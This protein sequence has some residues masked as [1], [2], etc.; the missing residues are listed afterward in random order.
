MAEKPKIPPTFM[1]PAYIVQ[2]EPDLFEMYRDIEVEENGKREKNGRKIGPIMVLRSAQKGEK[3][4]FI[5]SRPDGKVL[6][7]TRIDSRKPELEDLLAPN[8]QPK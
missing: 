4:D 3:V 1:T 5:S 2:V 7:L 6:E 8:F